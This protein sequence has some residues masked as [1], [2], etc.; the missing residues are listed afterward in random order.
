MRKTIPFETVRKVLAARQATQKANDAAN[1]AALA[2]DRVKNNRSALRSA[3]R[4]ASLA[5]GDVCAAEERELYATRDFF[6]EWCRSV[7]IDADLDPDA[8]EA[9][10]RDS[11]AMFRAVQ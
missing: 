1:K 4:V 3:M 8:H 11:L 6:E 2:A 9:A 7:E 10:L 5:E